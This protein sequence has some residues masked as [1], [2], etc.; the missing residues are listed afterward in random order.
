[1]STSIAFARRKGWYRAYTGVKWFKMMSKLRYIVREEVGIVINLPGC[2]VGGWFSNAVA[3]FSNNTKKRQK[4]QVCL[5]AGLAFVSAGLR[6]KVM[7]TMKVVIAA[8][9]QV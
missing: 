1:M 3:D 4:A 2:E 7:R 6:T 5:G 9:V 8:S